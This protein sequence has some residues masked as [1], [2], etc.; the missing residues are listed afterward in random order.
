MYCLGVLLL[1]HDLSNCMT[2]CQN[3]RGVDQELQRLGEQVADQRAHVAAD[4]SR[5]LDGQLR[6]LPKN[7]DENFFERHPSTG[8]CIVYRGIDGHFSLRYS[9]LSL[10]F[11]WRLEQTLNDLGLS[12]NENSRITEGHEHASSQE[13][14]DPPDEV[15]SAPTS[16]SSLIKKVSNAAKFLTKIK[17]TLSF[18]QKNPTT[19]HGSLRRMRKRIQMMNCALKSLNFSDK[20]L[21]DDETE[22]LMHTFVNFESIGTQQEE[23]VDGDASVLL[24]DDRALLIKCYL[25]DMYALL[26]VTQ[27]KSPEHYNDSLWYKTSTMEAVTKFREVRRRLMLMQRMQ[28]WCRPLGWMKYTTPIDEEETDELTPFEDREMWA[29]AMCGFKDFKD[30]QFHE[31]I[32]GKIKKVSCSI[33]LPLVSFSHFR[34]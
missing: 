33:L 16:S 9:D 4:L 23:K 12:S 28:T 22:N 11:L 30:V 31:L 19:D 13:T 17:R 14:V 26:K 7:V 5:R 20:E 8:E 32:R 2:H 6:A 21:G 29:T 3:R 15:S 24:Q 10:N 27:D 34:V 18:Q 25:Q 1:K